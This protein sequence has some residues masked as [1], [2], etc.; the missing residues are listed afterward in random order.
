MR[1]AVLYPYC[2]E[3]FL[4]VKLF[5]KLQED[6]E[7]VHLMAP[8]GFGYTNKDIGY[9]CNYDKTGRNVYSVFPEEDDE[10]QILLLYEPMLQRGEYDWEK[11]INEAIS[12]NKEVKFFS[13]TENNIP[14][15]V[16]R[17]ETKYPKLIKIDV[18]STMETETG[19]VKV[20][21]PEIPVI[22]VGGLL[23]EADC[24]SALLVLVEKFKREG[25]R[26]AV[27]SNHPLASLFGFYSLGHIW[28]DRNL[29]E[30]EKIRLINLYV[31]YV[32]FRTGVQC[33]IFELPDVLLKYNELAPNGYGIKSYM[34]G[35][36]VAP[37]F[38]LGCF[39][40]DI[41]NAPLINML[42]EDF[43]V[44]YGCELGAVHISNI[45]LDNA[46]SSKKQRTEVLRVDHDFVK[47]R[48]EE[49]REKLNVPLID[50]INEG[51]EELY[52]RIISGN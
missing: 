38:L 1:K 7:I 31:N 19:D 8:N 26:I 37:D 15:I 52:E 28:S 41:A 33:A 22:F 6:Y 34:L 17:L 12:R 42:S 44:R 4:A 24:F 35:Q 21:S 47:E 32:V 20:H 48:I 29:T 5:E 25:E 13:N 27:F 16:R 51:V 10:W 14:D 50:L 23:M 11:V 40:L 39:S 30:N 46:D 45:I 49:Q 2:G 43:K 18:C 9:A 36:A 3:V